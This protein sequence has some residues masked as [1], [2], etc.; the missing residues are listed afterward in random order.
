MPER[1]PG[2]LNSSVHRVTFRG[3]V[4]FG[5]PDLETGTYLVVYGRQVEHWPGFDVLMRGGVRSFRLKERPSRADLVAIEDVLDRSPVPFVVGLGDGVVL[6]LVKL[7][8]LKRG[9]KRVLVPAGAE[10]WRAVTG[11][12][13]IDNGDRTRTSLADDR[14]GVADV[15]IVPEWWQAEPRASAALHR[16]DSTIHAVESLLSKCSQ[17]LSAALAESALA[18]LGTGSAPTEGILGAFLAAEA[19]GSTKLGIAHALA[20]PLGAALGISHDTI[21]CVLGCHLPAFWSEDRVAWARISEAM[22]ITAGPAAITERFDSQRE[23]AG[24][25]RTLRELG[26]GWEVV[27]GVIDRAARSSGIPWLPRSIERDGILAF[28]RLVWS[29]SQAS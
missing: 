19:F 7:A 15:T 8:T 4:R 23:I 26:I 17:P 13:T 29:G 27:A 24:L 21:N 6:D 14:L 2:P 28:A 12:A 22:G 1:T 20:S 3:T 5:D 9:C 18:R 11:F 16:L 25:P 10:P